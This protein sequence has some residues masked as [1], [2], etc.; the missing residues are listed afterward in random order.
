MKQKKATKLAGRLWLEKR[1]QGFLGRGRIELLEMI[2]EYGSISQAAKAMKMSYKAAWDAVEAMNNLA[3]EPVVVRV[4][5]G[6]HGG[7]TQLTDYGKAL[8]E[9]FRAV[10]ER[11]QRWLAGLGEG[12]R[13][14]DK[15]HNFLGRLTMKTSARNQFLGRVESVTPGAVNAEVVLDI[16]GGDRL[17]AIITNESVRNLDLKAGAE[18]FALIKAPA[19]IVTT[20]EN[21]RTSARNRLCGTVSY[22]KEGAVNGE[23]RIEL[24]G[25]KTVVSVI[26]NESIRNLGL[27]E[28]VRACAVIDASSVILAVNA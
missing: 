2:G 22:C 10:E 3:D 20:D 7:G 13:D 21:L 23:V 26:T 19:V 24:P 14:F 6:R 4:T 5:G 15:L 18:V 8:V 16:G 12:V 1:G 11:Y 28:G 17:V 9:A 25:G 27:R